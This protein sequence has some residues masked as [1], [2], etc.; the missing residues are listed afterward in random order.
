MVPWGSAQD[1]IILEGLSRAVSET[2]ATREG[3]FGEQLFRQTCA[4]FRQT[5]S[6]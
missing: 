2:R 3:N 6:V 4:G 1:G 5:V